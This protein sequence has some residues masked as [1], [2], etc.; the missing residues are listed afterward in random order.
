MENNKYHLS[1]KAAFASEYA[2]ALK[3]QNFHWNTE[4]ASF[5]Q[6]HLLFERIYD[7]VYGSID[8]FAEN[9]RKSGAYTP[10]SLSR[11]SMLT[12]VEDENQV[13]DPRAMTA[14]LLADSDKLAQLMAMVYKMADAAGEFGL[15]NFLADRQDAHRKHSW[16]LRSTLK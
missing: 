1:I 6:L 7:E 4:G 10:A 2:F 15:S 16:F 3:A 12:T 11:F 8:A 13:I 14:E 5:Y 9:I